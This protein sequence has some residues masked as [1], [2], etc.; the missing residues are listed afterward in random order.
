MISVIIP[1]FSERP[2]LAA[3]FGS[4]QAET[5]PSDF[6]SRYKNLVHQSSGLGAPVACASHGRRRFVERL[7]AR[8]CDG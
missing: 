3:L 1:V 8:A 4:D 7:K 6:F 2:E 5:I